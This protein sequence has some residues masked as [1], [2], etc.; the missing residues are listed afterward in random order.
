ML[1]EPRDVISPFLSAPRSHPSVDVQ[2]IWARRA[3]IAL[4]ED[5][6]ME[7]GLQGKARVRGLMGQNPVA[8]SCASPIRGLP[9]FRT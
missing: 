9:N 8:R 2:T 7:Q 6:G 1:R 3:F 5:V 4:V